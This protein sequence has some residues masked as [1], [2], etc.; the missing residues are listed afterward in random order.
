MQAIV[1][2]DLAYKLAAN[3][4]IFHSIGVK[5][6][7]GTWS[8]LVKADVL[9]QINDASRGDETYSDTILRMTLPGRH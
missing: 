9:A 2:S 1:V 6:D 5:L 4:H 8:V 7:D 3:A